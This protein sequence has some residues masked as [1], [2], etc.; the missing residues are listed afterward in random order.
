MVEHNFIFSGL[1]EAIESY[2]DPSPEPMIPDLT[3][4]ETNPENLSETVSEQS[5]IPDQPEAAENP[6]QLDSENQPAGSEVSEEK[7]VNITDISDSGAVSDRDSQETVAVSEYY[8]FPAQQ[9]TEGT[10]I[11]SGTV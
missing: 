3:Q 5:E 1:K 7:A 10:G 4:T 9:D 8:V 2:L 11:V 6:E